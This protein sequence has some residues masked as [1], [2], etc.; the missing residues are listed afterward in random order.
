MVTIGRHSR[1]YNDFG[2]NEEIME[3][4]I[5]YE[6]L[7]MICWLMIVNEISAFLIVYM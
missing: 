2:I 1:N 4:W 5:D 7:S 3:Y 6:V